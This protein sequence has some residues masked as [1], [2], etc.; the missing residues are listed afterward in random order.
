MANDRVV[1]IV[2]Q[3]SEVAA[4]LT[5]FPCLLTR[6]NFPDEM[7]YG[8][9]AARS[10]GGDLRFYTDSGGTTEIPREIVAFEHDSSLGAD[11][12]SIQVWVK[13]PSVSSST[14][15]TIYCQ[16]GD[17]TLTDYAVTATY[18]RNA[19]WSAFLLVYHFGDDPGGA[20]PQLIDSTGNIN[21]TVSGTIARSASSPLGGDYWD[22]DTAI[23]TGAGSV[24]SDHNNLRISLWIRPDLARQQGYFQSGDSLGRP[25]LG[26]WDA[27]GELRVYSGSS[28][29]RWVSADGVI[30]TSAWQKIDAEYDELR[31]GFWNVYVGG[32][33]ITP[34][35]NNAASISGSDAAPIVGD[36]TTWNSLSGGYAFLAFEANARDANWIATEYNNQASPSTFAIAGTPGDVGGGTTVTVAAATLAYTGQALTVSAATVLPVAA[37]AVTYAGPAIPV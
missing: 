35:S 5:D 12:A 21:A 2:I 8:A 27:N 4:N 15:T 36:L 9:N 30:T 10:D 17:G 37:G 24:V 25:A 18:G 34:A 20:A 23:A 11:D 3:A 7:F 16:Y 31:S 1:A 6:A 28:T 14:D 29:T 33:L 32:T 22:F 13:I 26:T 19:V